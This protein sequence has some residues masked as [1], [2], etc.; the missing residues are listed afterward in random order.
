MIFGKE[1]KYVT[2]PYREV[3]CGCGQRK[4]VVA[5]HILTDLGTGVVRSTR[6]CEMCSAVFVQ[7]VVSAWSVLHPIDRRP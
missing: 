7:Q 5:I 2:S 6:L 3:C 1:K 4:Q